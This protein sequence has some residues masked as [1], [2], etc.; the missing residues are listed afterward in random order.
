ML[1][2]SGIGDV[3]VSGEIAY[4]AEG[5]LRSYAGIETPSSVEEMERT[6]PR[7]IDRENHPE[8]LLESVLRFE[9]LM[10]WSA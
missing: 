10:E 5:N 6:G 9:T 4:Q 8:S 2:E 7:M 3:E 1:T